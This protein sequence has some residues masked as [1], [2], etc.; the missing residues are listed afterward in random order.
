[1]IITYYPHSKNNLKFLK[2]ENKKNIQNMFQK[3]KISRVLYAM[4][5]DGM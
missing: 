3:L 5:V 4:H 1:M 2:F